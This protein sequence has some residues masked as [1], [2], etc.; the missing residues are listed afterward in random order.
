[1]QKVLGV[2]IAVLPCSLITSIQIQS[3]L[4]CCS[5]ITQIVILDEP[6]S[7]MDPEARRQTWDILQVHVHLIIQAKVF[8]KVYLSKKCVVVCLAGRTSYISRF[9]SV[10]VTRPPMLKIFLEGILSATTTTT[11]TCTFLVVCLIK[12]APLSNARPKNDAIHSPCRARGW[13]GRSCCPLTSWTRR[14]CSEIGSP[15]WPRASWSAPD[16]PSSLKTNTVSSSC[17]LFVMYMCHN[18]LWPH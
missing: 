11:T 6:T 9:I 4:I 1:M 12:A 10:E 14:T 17:Q 18:H 7:G 3:L 8:L 16:L 5:L 2:E 13:G 15:S